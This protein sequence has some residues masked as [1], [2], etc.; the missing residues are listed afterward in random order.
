VPGK[1][2][3]NQQAKLYMNLRR[4]HTR[5][6]AAAKADF[7]ASTGARFDV[8]PRMPSQGLTEEGAAWTAACRP[9]GGT[10]TARSCR[11]C[12]RR[13]DCGRS[14]SCWRCSDGMRTSPTICAAHWSVASAWSASSVGFHRCQRARCVSLPPGVLG[15]GAD[16]RGI[17]RQELRRL[18]EGLQNALWVLGGA[19][20]TPQRQPLGGVLQSRSRRGGGS[21]RAPRGVVRV[22]TA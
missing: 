18:A 13:L 21:D 7:N 3:T 14:A 6:T 8:D 1:H 19:G 16:P 17:G 20:G 12:V 22:M 15:L 5:E 2:I 11:C 10:G 9:I 4:T